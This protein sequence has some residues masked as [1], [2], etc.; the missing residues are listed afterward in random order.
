MSDYADK[1]SI[2]AMNKRRFADV[3]I[4]GLGTL[5]IR[6]LTERERSEYEA[7]FL[8][9]DGRATNLVDG[10]VRLIMLCV[11]NASGQRLF[12]D[13]DKPALEAMD[14]II[15]NRLV[16]ECRTHCGFTDED[17]DVLV[18][19]SDTTGGDDSPTG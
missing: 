8:D 16:D 5:R 12:S 15:T 17:M 10:K 13:A 14:S 3:E 19:N 1:A 6:S 7:G 18:K 4:P 11:C 9:S 2:L